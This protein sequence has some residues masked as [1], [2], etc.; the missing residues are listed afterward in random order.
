VQVIYVGRPLRDSIQCR[1]DHS[2]RY[3][4]GLQSRP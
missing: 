3:T 4:E 2:A 1:Y